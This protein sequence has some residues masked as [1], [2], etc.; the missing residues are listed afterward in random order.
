MELLAFLAIVGFAFSATA[1]FIHSV[2]TKKPWAYDVSRAFVMLEA[3][4][5]P[6]DLFRGERD[7]LESTS[8]PSRREADA[9]E[10]PVSAS[11]ES[12]QSSERLV[13]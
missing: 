13:A 6:L 1:Y 2:E 12:P 11:T 5:V 10:R 8:H 4:R 9:A 3:N 7:A